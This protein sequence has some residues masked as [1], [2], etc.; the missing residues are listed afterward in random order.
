MN[1]DLEYFR[2]ND[3]FTLVEENADQQRDRT[4]IRLVCHWKNQEWLWPQCEKP[5]QL[6]VKHLIQHEFYFLTNVKG[7]NRTQCL[8][9]MGDSAF[10]FFS[11]ALVNRAN[12]PGPPQQTHRVASSPTAER[13][14]ERLP[15]GPGPPGRIPRCRRHADRCIH[16]QTRRSWTVFGDV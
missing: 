8:N 5:H 15:D 2:A 16:P 14:W 1:S 12:A 3:P 11:S 7:H 13:E 9:T 4:L 6:M 10:T